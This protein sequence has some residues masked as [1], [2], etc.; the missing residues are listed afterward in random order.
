MGLFT[1]RFQTRVLSRRCR[2]TLRNLI[3]EGLEQRFLLASDFIYDQSASIIGFNAKLTNTATDIQL[4]NTNTNVVLRTLALNDFTGNVNIV[5]SQAGDTLTLDTVGLIT[6]KNFTFKGGTGN[7]S[8]SLVDSIES[9][10]FDVSLDA[11]TITIGASQEIFTSGA[12]Q[13]NSGSITLRGVNIEL[14]DSASLRAENGFGSNFLAGDVTVIAANAPSA[15]ASVFGDLL[16]PLLVADFNASIKLRN[17]NRIEGA[18][19]SFKTETATQTRWQDVGDYAK[20]IGDTL[21]TTLGQVSDLGLSLISPIS[22]QVKIQ[23]AAGDILLNSSVINASGRLTV[24]SDSSSDSSFDVV[25]INNLADALLPFIVVVGYGETFSRASIA[26]TGTTQMFANDDVTIKTEVGATSVVGARG[27]GNSRLSNSD[28]V[29]YAIALALSMN[30]AESTVSTSAGSKIESAL[31]SVFVKAIGKSETEASANAILFRDGIAGVAVSVAVDKATVTSKVDGTIIAGASQGAVKYAFNSAQVVNVADNSITLAGIPSEN[32][33]ERG[34]K[35]VYHAEGNTAIGGLVEGNEY[36]VA[37]VENVPAGN[38]FTGTQ[39][40]RLA[41]TLPLDL[42]A[43]QVLSNST[44]TLGKLALAPFSSSAVAADASNN[45]SIGLSGLNSG[46]KVTYLGPNSP[47]TELNITATFQ[48]LATG[49]TITRTDGGRSWE[50]LGLYIG[51]TI[52]LADAAGNSRVFR[53]K[54]FGSNRQTLIVQESN[55][56]SAGDFTGFS[57][58]TTVTEEDINANFQRQAS[59]D[60]ITRTDGKNWLQ[61]GLSTGQQIELVPSSG[62]SK[63]WTIK[64]FSP[65]GKTLVLAQANA[66]TNGLLTGFTLKTTP[67]G[68]GNLVQGQEYVVDVLAGKVRLRDPLAPANLIPFA[69]SGSGIQGFQYVSSSKS[70]APSSAVNS[71]RDTISITNH[72]FQTGDVLVYRTDPTKTIPENVYSFS[73]ASPNTP[74]VLGIANLPDAPV[75]GM[76]TG[77]YYYVTKVDANTIRLSEAALAAH[78]AEIIDLTSAPSGTQSFANPNSAIGIEITATLVASNSTG[79][80]TE[81]SD[82]EQ[83]WPDVVSTSATNGESALALINE[84]RKKANAKNVQTPG[85]PPAPSNACNSND[86]GIP[87]ELAGTFS[88]N[89][90]SHTVEAIVGSTAVLKSGKDILVQSS[91]TQSHNNS[92]S[93]EATRKGLDAADASNTGAQRKDIEISVAFS[94]VEAT[95]I[96][97]ATI[98]DNAKVDAIGVTTVDS[99]VQYPFRSDNAEG[100]VNPAEFEFRNL[101]QYSFLL[102]GT[103]GLAT[104][105]FNSQVTSIGGDPGSNSADKFLLGASIDL[106]FFNN[107]SIARIGK[108]AAINQNVAYQNPNQSVNATSLT[109]MQTIDVVSNAAF[110][111][112]IPNL[113]ETGTGVFKEGFNPKNVLQNFI[114]PFGISGENA[115]GPSVIVSISNNKTIAFV[116]DNAVIRT[117][118]NST[119]L[120]VL[121]T[122]DIFSLGISQTGAKASEFGLTASVSVDDLTSETRADI[123]KNVTITGGGISVE[124]IDTVNRYG[125]D[126]GYVSGEKIGVGIAI[127]VNLQE[128]TTL[129]YIGSE[130]P[131]TDSETGAAKINVSGPVSVKAAE[132][133]DLFALSLA[134]VVL[135]EPDNNPTPMQPPVGG[136]DPNCVP[137][138]DNPIGGVPVDPQKINFTFSVGASVAVNEGKNVVKAFVDDPAITARSLDIDASN[139]VESRTIVIGGAVGATKA[140]T[141]VG[142]GGAFAVNTLKVKT[143]AFLRDSEVV[144]IGTANVAGFKVNAED[145]STIYSD[146]GGVALLI[147]RGAQN[148]TNIGIG[149]GVAINLIEGDTKAFIENATVTAS[150]GNVVIN[151]LYAPKI[152]ALTIGGAGAVTLS[153]SDSTNIT[154]AGAGAKNVILSGGAQA[155]ASNTA[156]FA[157][158]NALIV[159]ATDHSDITVDAGAV[160]FAIV[161]AAGGNYTNLSFAA[162]V[163]INEITSQTRAYMFKPTINAKDVS[164]TATSDALIDSFTIGGAVASGA[165]SGAGSGNTITTTTEATIDGGDRLAFNGGVLATGNV[166]VSALNSSTIIADA[167]GFSLAITLSQQSGGLA[168]TGSIGIGASLNKIDSKT[169]ATIRDIVVAANTGTLTLEAKATPTIK[170]LSMAGAGAVGYSQSSSA[171]TFAGAGA[172]S[173]NDIK[174]VVNAAIDDIDDTSTTLV[175][176][177][178]LNVLATDTSSIVANAGGIALALG[179]AGGNANINVSIGASVAINKINAQTIATVNDATARSLVGAAANRATSSA[180]IDALTIAG[181]GAVA[182]STGSSGFGVSVAGA[183][184]G[185]GNA[186]T[187]TTSALVVGAV[188]NATTTLDVFSTNTSAINAKAISG[189]LSI[190]SGQGASVAIGFA[191]AENT[192][193]AN[194]FAN[195]NSSQ[196]SSG[197][198]MTLSARSNASIEALTVGVAASVAVNSGSGTLTLA[199]AGAGARSTNKLTGTIESSIIGA[200]VVSTVAGGNGNISMFALDTNTIRAD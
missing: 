70:F 35:L 89:V 74:S 12:G 126:G 24:I 134:G 185:S 82:G 26:I 83:P 106:L 175:T 176:A 49:D 98:A 40:I 39:K 154:G 150:A 68:I 109:L 47:V 169:L 170:A 41:T 62:A 11:E 172:G 168:A 72:G 122:Q 28:N 45:L 108:S 100:I 155:Y 187:S 99:K 90:F 158:N 31:G 144:T 161:L 159:N 46:T 139:D 96:S 59:G 179:I 86:S 195:M 127:A 162:S 61:L 53:V 151:A 104:Q 4:V 133:G 198:N 81:L 194:V 95:N 118:S 152:D 37:D 148:P 73:S 92:A 58:K 13:R 114:N 36:V 80:G 112:S 9:S 197:G 48:R 160:A 156:V 18:N 75:D 65:D 5:G 180:T 10:G 102:D 44:Q 77:F 56:V 50:Q 76:K 1:R 16:S 33:I 137:P 131:T 87:L 188:L 94:L 178:T 125:I 7:D 119:G 136:N 27:S 184:T 147:S 88:I 25:G 174:S 2:R 183:G 110:N 30:N 132:H 32:P 120:A 116:D 105:L 85:T 186:I 164:V 163:A 91:I 181:A 111:L 17:N 193:D 157:A 190:Q 199:G 71:D 57:L 173:G 113:I 140:G 14:Q 101:D 19:V 143:E 124:A 6:F 3:L 43:S 93:S 23:K 78:D 21:F 121:A 8:I 103:L 64:S 177:G 69:G 171:F 189:S 20:G 29:D 38:T 84:L 153:N 200:S 107:E 142:I 52:Q 196:V 22:G 63:S 66:V 129:A 135:T 34:Q 97:H 141:N 192:I 146:G 67:A 182:L 51:Q 138:K 123:G 60:T 15:G 191:I 128:R 165:F 115:I 117:G 79:A 167:G 149:I 145:A 55:A 130:S 42:D 54:G 166:T